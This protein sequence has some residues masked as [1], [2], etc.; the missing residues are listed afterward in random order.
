MPF[1]LA[2]S[3]VSRVAP[4][5]HIL[6]PSQVVMRMMLT[7]VMLCEYVLLFEH[8]YANRGYQ[9]VHRLRRP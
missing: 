8:E 4:R 1:M 3:V 5:V 9:Y 2:G 7:L 6:L